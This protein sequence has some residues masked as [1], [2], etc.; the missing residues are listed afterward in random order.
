MHPIRHCVQGIKDLDKRSD[1]FGSQSGPEEELECETV[2]V[3][4]GSNLLQY[5]V[6]S[7][8]P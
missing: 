5:T 8:A 3:L 4:F 6:T 1:R 7:A 2:I